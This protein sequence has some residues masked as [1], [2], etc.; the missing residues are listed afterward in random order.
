MPTGTEDEA[1]GLHYVVNN[2]LTPETETSTHY[3]WSV[4]RNYNLND[5][6][7]S[8]VLRSEMIRAFEEDKA[9]I[10][11]QQK[12]MD[13]ETPRT[14]IIPIKADAAA[15]AMRRVLERLEREEKAQASA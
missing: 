3:F 9:V 5:D 12:M 11:I 1:G 15:L 2:S 10:E 6:N 8:Q 7:T 4:P 14:P 13:M